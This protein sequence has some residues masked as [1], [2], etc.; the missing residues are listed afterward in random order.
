[1]E[2]IIRIV[3]VTALLCALEV[4]VAPPALATDVSM[5]PTPYDNPYAVETNK[6]PYAYVYFYDVD[7]AETYTLFIG[8]KE[9]ARIPITEDLIGRAQYTYKFR[10]PWGHHLGHVEDSSGT[11][12]ADYFEYSAIHVEFHLRLTPN[13]VK[14]YDGE[15]LSI[16]ICY[17]VD[18]PDLSF[19][20]SGKAWINGYRHWNGIVLE[21]GTCTFVDRWDGSND[22]GDFA[23]PGYFAPVIHA[24]TR[25][26][27]YRFEEF[28]YVTD[29]KS[30]EIAF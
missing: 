23:Q 22:W 21:D 12:V 20:N 30:F 10:P 27:P 7:H 29:K 6:P 9:Y 18:K 28:S 4:V 15:L 14:L 2:R 24:A 1:M 25:F 5:S 26:G 3:A 8:R 19:P 11:V 16:R 17:D 13:P